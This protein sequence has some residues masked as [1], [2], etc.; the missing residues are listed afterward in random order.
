MKVVILENIE[1]GLEYI[2]IFESFSQKGKFML[3][4]AKESNSQWTY[5]YFGEKPEFYIKSQ[6]NEV[7]ILNDDFSIR[8]KSNDDFLKLCAR[9]INKESS[10]NN[11]PFMGGLIGYV[12]YDFSKSYEPKLISENNDEINTPDAIFAYYKRFFIYDNELKKLFLVELTDDVDSVDVVKA[13]LKKYYHEILDSALNLRRDIKVLKK[14]KVEFK[15]N[16]S[17]EEFCDLVDKAKK[18]IEEGEV[19]QVVLSQQIK[20]DINKSPLEIYKKLKVNNPSPY[21]Y[22]FEFD[23]F[24]IIGSSP[25]SLVSLK[26]N[27]AMTNP[28]AGTIKRGEDLDINLINILK[29]DEKEKAEHMMLLDLGRND[30]GKVSEFGTV[31]VKEFMKEKLFS[32]VIHLSSTVTGKLRD[33]LNSIDLLKST[34]P[35]GTVSGAPKHRAMEVIEELEN[36]KRGIYSGAIGYFSVNGNMDMAIAIR[37]MI[38]K[39]RKAYIQAGAGIVYDSV[40]ERE[41]YETLN[42]LAALMEVLK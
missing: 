24:D 33:D 13:N 15:S 4:I 39:G 21:M 25:E 8:E 40:N 38:I 28:I 5:S 29:K 10:I 20:V 26:G 42:K 31:K 34:M 17:K 41:Y 23:N 14:T 2:E 6:N 27:E 30:I 32:H 35:A 19:F 12:S 3:E 1:F 11:F 18:Y 9:F 22:Y 7:F 37:T 16:Y 36:R